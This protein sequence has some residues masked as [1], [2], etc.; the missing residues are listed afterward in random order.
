MTSRARARAAVA[1][2]AR[3]AQIRG[4]PEGGAPDPYDC[5]PE[6]R[7]QLA[8]PAVARPSTT[9]ALRTGLAFSQQRAL[10]E[11]TPADVWK[12]APVTAGVESWNLGFPLHA[13]AASGPSPR[14]WDGEPG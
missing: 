1:R 12:A 5:A 2:A 11:S 4:C 9:A 13:I 10:S 14:Y 8:G 6:R 7:H 3:S